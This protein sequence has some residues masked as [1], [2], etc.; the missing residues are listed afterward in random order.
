MWWYQ[1]PAQ[2]IQPSQASKVKRLLIKV[3]NIMIIICSC[4][5]NSHSL[6]DSVHNS[7][8]YTH[9]KL[10]FIEAQLITLSVIIFYS[11]DI[12]KK[13][14]VLLLKPFVWYCF[15]EKELLIIII[16]MNNGKNIHTRSPT[17]AAIEPHRREEHAYYVRRVYRAVFVLTLVIMKMHKV[18]GKVAVIYFHMALWSC[19]YGIST[20]SANFNISMMI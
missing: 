16:I 5:E 10:I 7:K 12:V 2:Q 19:T 4:R 6:Y 17:A 1:M 8:M 11:F 9:H 18:E 15:C 14:L 13:A 20:L 3:V